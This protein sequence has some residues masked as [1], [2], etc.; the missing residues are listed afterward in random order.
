MVQEIVNHNYDIKDDE[1]EVLYKNLTSSIYQ[2]LPQ[3][4]PIYE[5]AKALK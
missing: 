3:K 1:G 4:D 2:N 5:N